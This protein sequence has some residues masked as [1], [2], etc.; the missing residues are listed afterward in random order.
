MIKRILS[1]VLIFCAVHTMVAQTPARVTVAVSEAQLERC[2]DGPYE[3]TWESI[4]ENYHVPEWFKD[5]KFGIFIHWGLYSVPAMGSEWYPK[6]MYNAMSEEHRKRFG[7]Q[8]NFGYKDFI[9]MFRAEKFDAR[10]WAALF[11]EAGARYVIPTA[12]HHD[13]F[14]M[15][16]TKYS[17]WNARRMGPKRDVIGELAE[18]V[19]NEGMKFGVSNHRIENWDF[20][21]PLTMD[22]D[23]TDLFLPKYAGLYGPPQKPTEQSGMGPKAQAAAVKGATEAVIDE[24]AR[25]GRHPQSDAF[26]NEWEMRVHELIDKYQ[27]DLLYFDNGI[28]YRSLD[29]WKLRLARYY[30]N[31]AAQWGRE[32]SIQSKSQAYLAG[33]IRDYEREGRAPKQLTDDYWQVDDPIGHKFGYV[34]GL[35]L[36]SAEEI[37]RSLVEN[38]SKNGNLCLNVSPRSDGTI[39]DDQR[40]V[41][42]A[43]G[44]WLKTYGD[45]VYGSRACQVYGE[46]N[47]RYTQKDSCIYAFVLKWDGRPFAIHNLT[48]ADIESVTDMATG[49]AVDFHVA[50][51]GGVCIEA[52]GEPVNAAAG[53]RIK[54]KKGRRF[55]F[56][57]DSI[58]DGGWGRSAGSSTPSAQRNQRD[59]NHLYGHSF[60]MLCAARWQSDH[61]EL[62]SQFFNRGISGNTLHDLAQRWQQDA[63]ELK[64]D[65]VTLLIGT[66]DVSD[67]LEGKATFDLRQWESDYRH[68]LDQLRAQNPQVELLLC[69]P[70]VASSGKIGAADDYSRRKALIA[71]FAVVV[72]NIANDYHAILLD[73]NRMFERLTEQHPEWW[74]WDGIHPTPAGHQK[75]ADLWLSQF[76]KR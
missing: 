73:Y 36:Q 23:S 14:A 5:A 67:L 74:V 33:S 68:L 18:A 11:R 45:G 27:P 38:I 12:E 52:Q 71:E 37:I 34:E 21:Y 35:Q 3:A 29:P 56:I 16:D 48:E 39:P 1:F 55:L 59:W 44:R 61:P 30:Y 42:L 10:E 2:P 41:L 7:D 4:A 40:E 24:A 26:L 54:V 13:G 57:G 70:F 64:P 46:D 75:M 20:M 32:V 31:S 15:Y 47:V 72:R 76:T 58:T 69:T 43:V 50:T 65:V 62:E 63:L 53:F 17:K 66:N 25:E 51:D 28:N 6:H 49:H 19:R 9:P 60:M 22:P 8:R